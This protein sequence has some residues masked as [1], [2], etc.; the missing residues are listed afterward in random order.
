[1]T[2]LVLALPL[3]CWGLAARTA[4]T[5]W[6]VAVVL[7]FCAVSEIVLSK[8]WLLAGERF[9]LVVAFALVA[10]VALA[11]GIAAD[12][13]QPGGLWRAGARVVAGVAVSVACI[14]ASLGGITVFVLAVLAYGS[15]ASVPPA[16]GVLPLPA[17]LAVTSNRAQGCS[18]G[19]QTYCTR[20][21]VVQGPAGLPGSQVAR[22]VLSQL[23]RAYGWHLTSGG[24]GYWDGCRTEGWLLDAHQVCASITG[25][26][27]EATIS[28]QTSDSW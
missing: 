16:A 12:R 26:Q 19:S 18:A 15:P 21:I 20:Q 6:I 17:R 1:M 2:V 3:A 14:T 22:R 24:P 23:T 5:G 8:G 9:T 25:S 4:R 27:H 11:T 28:I 7:A 10:A 13:R